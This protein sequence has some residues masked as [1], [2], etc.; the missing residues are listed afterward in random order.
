MD[1][2]GM[3]EKL[4]EALCSLQIR[5][6]W[7]R[8]VCPGAPYLAPMDNVAYSERNGGASGTSHRANVD[9]SACIVVATLDPNMHCEAFVDRNPVPLTSTWST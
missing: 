8:P 4:T 7:W 5:Q 9:D 2:G 1:A 6:G 3:N